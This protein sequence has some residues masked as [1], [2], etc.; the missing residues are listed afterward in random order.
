MPV[1]LTTRGVHHVSLTVAD[2]P[3]TRQFYTDVLGFQAVLELPPAVL[4]SDG[5]TVIGVHPAPDP[6]RAPRDD[7]FDENRIG[8]DH[9]AFT[10]ESRA[11]L[12]QAIA[13]FDKHGVSHGAIEDLGPAIGLNLY[14]IFFRDPDGIQLE[15]SA[16][17]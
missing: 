3:R 16:P 9:L 17:Y 5:S 8:L 2:V 12:E 7:R 15:L 11:D 14:V 1:Q 10:V 13:I 6:A 4:L